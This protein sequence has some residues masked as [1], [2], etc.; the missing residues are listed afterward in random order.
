MG[1]DSL[2]A[3][4]ALRRCGG[5]LTAA[6]TY[7]INHGGLVPEEEEGGEEK[8]ENVPGMEEMAAG[9][10]RGGGAGGGASSS[11][12]NPS[13]SGVTVAIGKHCQV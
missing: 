13:L 2:S 4:R 12:S 3:S 5:E 1:F 8:Q 7:L 11:S 9:G 6:I 10:G